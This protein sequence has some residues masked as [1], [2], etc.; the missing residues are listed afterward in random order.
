MTL[1]NLIKSIRARLEE[2]AYLNE[3]AVSVGIVLPILRS[4]GWDDADPSQI[5]PEFSMPGE[6]VYSTNA[7]LGPRFRKK[8]RS[9]RIVSISGDNDASLAQ[10]KKENAADPTC[11][12]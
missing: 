5:V 4:L 12:N 2:G 7:C 1:Q 11:D 6:R 9:V 8:R 10:D 3:A